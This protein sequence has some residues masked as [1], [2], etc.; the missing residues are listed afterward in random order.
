MCLH[1]SFLIWQINCINNSG[2]IWKKFTQCFCLLICNL[3]TDRQSAVTWYN[4][5]FLSSRGH[6]N[7]HRGIWESI[8]RPRRAEE[9]HSGSQSALPGRWRTGLWELRHS[10][11][12]HLQDEKVCHITSHHIIRFCPFFSLSIQHCYYGYNTLPSPKIL[13]IF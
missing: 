7:G 12:G 1:G 5:V 9:H 11:E 4:I 6:A 3:L 10:I 13:R 2:L 8:R